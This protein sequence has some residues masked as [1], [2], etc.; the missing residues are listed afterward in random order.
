M[1]EQLVYQCATCGLAVA[2]TPEGTPI[3]GCKHDTAGIVANAVAKL[4][5]VGGLKQGAPK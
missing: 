2:L 5:G 4:G 3:R 1:F